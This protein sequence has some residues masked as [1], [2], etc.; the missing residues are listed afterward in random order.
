MKTRLLLIALTCLALT[1]FSTPLSAH[2][3]GAYFSGGIGE[4]RV[5]KYYFYSPPP[6]YIDYYFKGTN[7]LIGAGVVFDTCMGDDYLFNYRLQLGFD[8]FRYPKA[9]DIIWAEYNYKT[10]MSQ[11]HAFRLSLKNTFG[12]AFFRNNVFRAWAGFS[13]SA[14]YY[15]NNLSSM[16][17]NI[18]FPRFFVPGVVLGLNYN[19]NRLMSFFFECGLT[20]E[21]AA[22]QDNLD[23]MNSLNC[24][25]SVGILFRVK[26]ESDQNLQ[27]HL[28]L[29]PEKE[30]KKQQSTQKETMKQENPD[31]EK[32]EQQAPDNSLQKQ[33]APAKD[34][35]KPKITGQKEAEK[36]I[37]ER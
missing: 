15:P 9:P 17:S 1:G 12:F 6:V 29:L 8:E 13:I 33:A 11:G 30:I 31:K 28:M 14:F 4:S 32:T 27:R 25:L 10:D 35:Q 26:Q 2:G 22:P 37:Q 24:Y 7:Y 3:I 5:K 23:Y 20:Y 36:D 19:F 18:F 21:W 34:A 16:N